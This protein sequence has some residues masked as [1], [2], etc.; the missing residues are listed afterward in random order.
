MAETPQVL[1]I[2]PAR[3]GADAEI[4]QKNWIK[5]AGIS[6]V[7]R[8]I[9]CCV[10]AGYNYVVSTDLEDIPPYGWSTILAK[11]PLHTKNCKMAHVVK[12]VLERM[13]GPDEQI[14]LLV[15]PTQPLRK[16]MHLQSAVQLMVDE[17]WRSVASVVQVGH[18][19][20]VFK[21][22][23]DYLGFARVERRQDAQPLY[24]FDG[25]FYGVRRGF[26][27]AYGGLVTMATK[28][29]EIPK[30]ETCA[31]DTPEDWKIAEKLLA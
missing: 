18:L 17:G 27:A 4:P 1:C 24:A 30:S 15:Q 7:Q 12:D 26:W 11:A 31:L 3:F 2:I 28:T 9:T 6:P 22:R 20:K 16:V 14:I 19:G 25:T 13:D 21:N 5:L 23:L 29:V 8:A 10:N